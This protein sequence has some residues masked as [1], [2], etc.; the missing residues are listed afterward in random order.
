MQL[1]AGAILTGG[2]A[3]LPGVSHLANQVLDLTVKISNGSFV[4]GVPGHLQ[5]PLFSCALGLLIYTLQS[6]LDG[7]GSTESSQVVVGKDPIFKRFFGA[8]QGIFT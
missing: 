8:V 2:G 3:L 5:S 6:R 4:Q 1:K 7:V